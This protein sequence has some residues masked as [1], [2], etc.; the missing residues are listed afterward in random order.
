MRR[1]T[2]RRPKISLKLRALAASMLDQAQTLFDASADLDTD[3]RDTVAEGLARIVYAAYDTSAIAECVSDFDCV[4]YIQTK[5]CEWFR[6]RGFVEWFCVG[7]ST[8][9]R[10]SPRNFFRYKV[11]PGKKVTRIKREKVA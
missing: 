10:T 7:A 4:P 1:I 8:L 9:F 3:V 6:Q 5:T 11:T 2:Q